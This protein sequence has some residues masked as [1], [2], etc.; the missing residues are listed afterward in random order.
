VPLDD[1]QGCSLLITKEF[2]MNHQIHIVGVQFSTFTRAVQFCCEEIGLGYS[3]GSTVDGIDHGLRTPG[4]K[5]LNPFG[6]VP[7]LID[8]GRALYETQ[9][10][11]RYLDNVYNHARLQPE[12]PWQKA[13][14]DQWCA[15]ITAYVD[16]TIVRNYL[17]EFLFPKGEQGRVREDVVAA[18]MPE[19]IAIVEILE[20]QLGAREFLVGDQFTLADIMLAPV[21]NYLVGA[22]HHVDLVK[23]D[24]VL[25]AY[26]S[27]ILARSGARNVFIPPVL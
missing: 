11:C 18:A 19:V 15:A 8:K 3:L 12:D 22:P 21:V 4:L 10:I 1:C 7:V 20:R 13:Q 17:L 25:R 27:R 23:K 9:S 26:N 14:V 24:S 5:S 2:V 6:K 16:K